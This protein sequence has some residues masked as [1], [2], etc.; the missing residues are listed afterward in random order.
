MLY[1]WNILKE[2]VEEIKSRK[3]KKNSFLHV[4]FIGSKMNQEPPF[5]KQLFELRFRHLLDDFVLKKN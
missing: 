2:I 3:S 1:K 5:G 4:Q